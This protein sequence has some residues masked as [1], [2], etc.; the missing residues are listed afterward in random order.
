MGCTK[1]AQARGIEDQPVRQ[2]ADV[3]VRR[4]VDATAK[5]IRVSVQ[6]IKNIRK[7]RCRLQGPLSHH[8]DAGL[9]LN[10]KHSA[11]PI[12]P[13]AQV[14]VRHNE[15]LSRTPRAGVARN[16]GAPGTD[17]TAAVRSRNHRSRHPNSNIPSLFK[18]KASQ[19]THCLQITLQDTRRHR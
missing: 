12:H 16:P 19:F 10:A 11:R 15:I 2:L 14:S 8:L 7:H 9:R 4:A 13:L 1:N 3:I 18:Q 6:D 5:N 17:P